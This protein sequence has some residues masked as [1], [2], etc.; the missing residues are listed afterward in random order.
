MNQGICLQSM[1]AVRERPSERSEMTNQLL[2]G[3]L[4]EI[5]EKKDEWCLIKT[6][7]DNYEGW[8]NSLQLDLISESDFSAYKNSKRVYSLS[9]SNTA[10]RKESNNSYQYTFGSR[11]VL[12]DNN[13]F[14]IDGIKYLNEGKTTLDLSD[15]SLIDIAK[16]YLGSPYLWGGRSIFGID[17]SGFV[18]ICFK[19]TGTLLPRDAS[20]QVNYGETVNFIEETQVGDL[21][22]F[23]NE[24]GAIVHVGILLNNK[25]IIHA[26]GY[27]KIDDID[28]NGIFNKKLNRYTHKLRIIKRIK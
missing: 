12:F 10:K 16:F 21:A 5:L 11:L 20:Q 15:L 2:F 7:D 19:I 24:E 4:F 27:V 6:I 8:A 13:S 25:S 22:F 3:D 17:C 26:S 14:E 28:H 23:E 18:Q 9:T 1:V